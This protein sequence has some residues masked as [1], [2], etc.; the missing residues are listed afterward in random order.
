MVATSLALGHSL[1]RRSLA[2]FSSNTGSHRVVFLYMNP[3]NFT[4]Y[5]LLLP[6][7]HPTCP[8]VCIFF[9]CTNLLMVI[10]DTAQAASA[11]AA[12]LGFI[13]IASL[14]TITIALCLIGKHRGRT[15]EKR[16]SFTTPVIDICRL[17]HSNVERDSCTAEPQ[18]PREA[19]LSSNYRFPP[20][21]ASLC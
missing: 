20:T 4:S 12:C 10:L 2:L 8:V 21:P 9:G 15:R 17:A 5:T 19:Y 7:R 6:T 1:N 18:R 11:V 13:A 3:L 16:G 14:I